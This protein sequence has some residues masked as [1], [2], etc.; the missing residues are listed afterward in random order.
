MLRRIFER[1][2]CVVAEAAS[3]AEALTQATT[4]PE[5]VSAPTNTASPMVRTI[6]SVIG[7]YPRT[8][9]DTMVSA[10][11]AAPRL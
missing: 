2:G 11:Q 6:M 7:H 9:W 1:H 10:S 4:D 8:S 3:A 5:N